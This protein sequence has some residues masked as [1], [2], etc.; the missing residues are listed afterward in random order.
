MNDLKKYLKT[1]RSLFPIYGPYERRFYTD[2][3]NNIFEYSK[4][5][6]EPSLS[7]LENKF[8]SPP[9]IIS[10]YLA[11]IDTNYLSKQLSRSKYIRNT[12]AC[13]IIALI[14]ALVIWGGSNYKSYLDFQDALPA[15]EETT[16]EI[17]NED[18]N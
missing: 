13:T 8:G 10:E 6:M 17:H 15:I 9:N 1:I 11:N 16:I 7:D 4:N 12:C 3:K 14:I 5:C 18:S 2:L